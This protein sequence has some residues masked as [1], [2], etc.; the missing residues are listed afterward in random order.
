MAEVRTLRNVT[1]GTVVAERVATGSSLWARFRGLMGRGSLP[2]NEGLW[3][4]GTSNIHMLFMR[5]PIDCVFLGRPRPGGVT[6][7]VGVRHS[8][9]PWRGGVWYVGGAQGVV[10]LGEGALDTSGTSV[11]DEVLWEPLPGGGSADGG[12]RD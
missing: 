2:A 3:L 9:P 12:R 6:P 4:P 11:G 10:E 1:R 5:F 7:I 8:L